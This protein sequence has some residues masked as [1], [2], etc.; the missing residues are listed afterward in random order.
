[1]P[2]WR[3]R[4]HI[5]NNSCLVKL[6]AGYPRRRFQS[7]AGAR[8]HGGGG[9]VVKPVG[10]RNTALAA[11]LDELGWPIARLA[12]VVNREMGEAYVSRTTVSEWLNNSRV[13]RQPLP[14]VAA[15][16]LS[17]AKGVTVSVSSLWPGVATSALCIAA[18]EGMRVSWD[19]HGTRAL[20]SNWLA[21]GGDVFDSDRR[22]FMAVSG[23]ALTAPA[24]QYLEQI[25]NVPP[26][27]SFEKFLGASGFSNIKVSSTLV[28][29]YRSL[30]SAFR[31]MDDLE[32]GSTENLR[33]IRN[34]VGQVAGYLKNGSFAKLELKKSFLGVLAELAQ[35]AG[36]MAY[37][38]ERHGL[39]QRLFRTGLQA[40]HDVGDRNLGAH[41][42]ACMAYQAVN[43]NDLSSA[44]ELASVAVKVAAGAHPAVCSL[45]YSRLAYTKAATGD[46][47][48]FR[49]KIQEAQRLLHST[50]SAEAP[51][52]LYWF[53]YDVLN[54][55]QGHSIVRASLANQR[56]SN[57]LIAEADSSLNTTEG[58]Q[59]ETPRDASFH[60]A[61]LAR[62]HI[63]RGDLHRGM[64]I[65]ENVIDRMSAVS[66]PRSRR[67]L[68]DL[69]HDLSNLREG[70]KLSEVQALRQQLQPVLAAGV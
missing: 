45:A 39:A 28:E 20:I 8:R 1:M 50:H 49:A 56:N 70:K 13:P 36:W 30:T 53:N 24:R 68:Y 25:G 32:G 42:L 14:A 54:C 29:Y 21:N 41:I 52:W 51:S 31:Q 69:D 44:E 59:T 34:A 57:K 66:S 18:D 19:L 40:T 62:A 6:W 3:L 22:I 5:Y 43:R 11:V 10:G 9:V 63:R 37:D 33:H 47:N 26:P 67:V 2:S 58:E 35:I 23:T 12:H 46:V 65:A 55:Q 64:Y 60:E 17:Q 48:G 7:V 38:A 27:G 4:G 15:H 61:W 16:V